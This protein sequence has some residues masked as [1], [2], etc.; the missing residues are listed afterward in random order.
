ML[1]NKCGFNCNVIN[2]GVTMVDNNI[3]IAN[4]R[5][6]GMEDNLLE[7]IFLCIDLNCDSLSLLLP[8]P[9]AIDFISFVVNLN[10]LFLFA[11][12]LLLLPL[13]L[14]L[15]CMLPTILPRKPPAADPELLLLFL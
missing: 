9:N 2:I 8:S 10:E 14:L 12:V 4:W 13:P 11:F 6:D 15:F 3:H 5:I 7:Y 1:R